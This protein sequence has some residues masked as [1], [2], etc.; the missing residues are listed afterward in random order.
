MDSER[1]QWQD[2]SLE[3]QNSQGGFWEGEHYPDT[4]MKL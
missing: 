4:R 1:G 2:F 3:K